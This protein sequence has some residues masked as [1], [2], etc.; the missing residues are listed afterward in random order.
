MKIKLGFS[1]CPNDTFM[2]DA[3]YNQ[4]VDL[5]GYKF[6]FILE[7]ILHLNQRALNEELDMVKI[8]YNT[9]GHVRSQ[10]DL[11]ESG[12]ALGKN[13][14]PLLISKR[15]LSLNEI[16]NENLSVAIPGEKTTANLLLGYYSNHIQN[17]KV[18]L[19]HEIMPAILDGEVDAGVIIHENRFTYQNFGLQLVQD[20]GEYW[21]NKTELPIPLGAIVAHKK[22]GRKVIQDLNIIMKASVNHAME[23]TDS[24]MKFV[25]LHA[26]EMDEAVMKAHINLY[27]NDYSKELGPNGHRAVNHLLSVGNKMGLF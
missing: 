27:V 16:I 25:R 19:F 15:E 24:P 17:K 20:L 5:M 14:G 26:Q 22:L 11:L 23:H 10:Y 18:Y 12:S 9:Y 4:K 13:C 8:S 7:D 1:T 21:E 3:I 6:E 2:F